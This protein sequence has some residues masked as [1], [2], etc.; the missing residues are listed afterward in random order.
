MAG[1]EPGRNS[2]DDLGVLLEQLNEKGS[3]KT[4]LGRND[5]GTST[6]EVEARENK[7]VGR[8][9]PCLQTPSAEVAPVSIPIKS[10]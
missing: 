9:S 5:G 8:R 6:P 2:G 3:E 10:T 4:F 1:T 7:F